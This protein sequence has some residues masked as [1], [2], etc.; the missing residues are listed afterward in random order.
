MSENC[1]KAKAKLYQYL[2]DELDQATAESI[3]SH[4]DD[5]PDCLEPF[6]FER[7]LQMAIRKCLREDL[8]DGFEAR[9]RMVIRQETA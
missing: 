5:C 4:L 8:P 7:R 9:V 1:E 3:R 2:D 6:D